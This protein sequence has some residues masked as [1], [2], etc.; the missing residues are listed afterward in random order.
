[1]I[2]TTPHPLAVGKEYVT[3]ADPDPTGFSSAKMSPGQ[4]TMQSRLSTVTV[5]L[6]VA[7]FPDSSLV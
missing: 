5:K 2:V 3:V 6:Q 4:S 1:V 7:V